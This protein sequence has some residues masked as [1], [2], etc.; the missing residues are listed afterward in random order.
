MP[1][2]TYL[3]AAGLAVFLSVPVGP[4]GFAAGEQMV[5]GN[6]KTFAL[7]GVGCILAD[8]ALA[9]MAVTLLS[10]LPEFDATG[11]YHFWQ[12]WCMVG[13]VMVAAGIYLW[14]HLP[15][16]QS[17]EFQNPLMFGFG[18]TFFW[19]TSFIGITG[20]FAAAHFAGWLP[21]DLGTRLLMPV[22][23]G[24]GTTILWLLLGYCCYK[25]SQ[26]KR[27]SLQSVVNL[28]HR[29]MAGSV[30]VAGIIIMTKPFTV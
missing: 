12:L 8:I 24:V 20:A 10:V 6:R 2:Q 11:I 21:P 25:L 18:L 14:F 17:A 13:L 4:V 29:L 27:W 1:L 19:P 3:M 23:L 15:E 7:I 28:F 9:L 30:V 5:L 16:S 22:S 26:Q